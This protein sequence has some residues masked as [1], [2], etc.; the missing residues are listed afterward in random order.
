MKL[1]E[2]T[3][4]VVDDEPDLREIFSAW[5]R[6]HGCRVLTAANGREALEVLLSD[7][8]DVLISDVRMPV[9]GGV[10]LVREIFQRQLKIP[11]IIFVSGYADVEPR[12]MYG[13]GVEALMEKPLMRQDLLKALDRSLMRQEELWL[14]RSTAPMAQSLELEMPSLREAMETKAFL[15]G[16]GGCS[17]LSEQPLT[18]EKTI[19]LSI[20]FEREDL[21]LKAQGTVRWFAQE[22][23]HAGIS[24]DYLSVV[25]RE[26]VFAAMNERDACRSFIPQCLPAGAAKPGSA[27]E[28]TLVNDPPN[29]PF[30]TPNAA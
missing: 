10:E 19:E 11:S 18:A 16:H 2:A 14:T 17:V 26:W 6:R 24:F 1:A 4:L 23:K 3:V 21:E 25:S 20:H 8:V 12:E 22:D 5:L 9:M 15:L 28:P 30:S 7:K 13:L 27:L 29:Y